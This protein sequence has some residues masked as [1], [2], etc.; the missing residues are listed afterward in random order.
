MSDEDFDNDYSIIRSNAV[1]FVLN[2]KAYVTTGAAPQLLGSVWEYEPATDLWEQRTPFEGTARQD[3]VAFSTENGRAFVVTGR[4]SSFSF[5][6][7]WEFKPADPY[8]KED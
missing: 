3:A 2:N 4:S 6:D 1:A 7:I 8:D 5:D